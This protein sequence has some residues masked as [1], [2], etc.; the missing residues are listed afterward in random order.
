MFHY[1]ICFT[2]PLILQYNLHLPV[3]IELLLLFYI[4]ISS[5]Q[6]FQLDNLWKR[7]RFLVRWTL[8]TFCFKKL[9]ILHSF[10]SFFSLI[11]VSNGK[12]WLLS[13]FSNVTYSYKCTFLFLIFVNSPY[14]FSCTLS[15]TKRKSKGKN[16]CSNHSACHWYLSI[17]HFE[18]SD[19][20]HSSHRWPYIRYCVLLNFLH[21][22]NI[23][24]V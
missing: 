21:F 24:F 7:M 17:F 9:T 8:N 4:Y 16:T 13:S 6:Q 2:R 11:N 3:G 12:L 10:V 20:T 23:S 14:D 5:Q 22:M 1:N 18:N 15:N 19:L